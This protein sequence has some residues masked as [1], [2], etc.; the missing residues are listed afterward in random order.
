MSAYREGN[1][2]DLGFTQLQV[3]DACSGL[4]FFFPLIIMGILLAYFYRTG[5]WKG[6]W[7]SFSAIPLSVIMNSLRIAMT[8]VLYQHFGAGVAEGFFHGF[9]GWLIFM[10]SFAV[11]F[12]EIWLLKRIFPGRKEMKTQEPIPGRLPENQGE[13]LPAASAGNWSKILTGPPQ[14]LFSSALIVLTLLFFQGIEFRDKIASRK[15]LPNFPTTVGQWSGARQ[16]L[17]QKFI[18][19]LDF[20]DYIIVDYRNGSGELV[21]FYV[22]Y[23]ESQRKGESIHSPET[24]LPGSGWVFRQAGTTPIALQGGKMM[25][26]NRAIMEK[27]GSRQLVYYWFPARGRILTNAYELKLYGFWD[28]LTRQRTDAALVR[29]ITPILPGENPNQPEKRLQ[30]LILQLQPILAEFIPN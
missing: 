4:R 14:S 19:E 20:T 29:V 24:C 30:N 6:V 25:T 15:P 27:A 11:L 21:N 23:Y 3:V 22:A 18:A 2:I 10:V 17:D 5:F 1:V 28:A 9:S 16:F 12:G 26:V 7:V 13:A 8:G